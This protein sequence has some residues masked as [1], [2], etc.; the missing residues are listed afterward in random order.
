M[1]KSK[2][3]AWD[4]W[5][6]ILKKVTSLQGIS[7]VRWSWNIL[8]SSIWEEHSLGY[9]VPIWSHKRS[10]VCWEYNVSIGMP[11]LGSIPIH[12][13]L[14]SRLW[15]HDACWIQ[16]GSKCSCQICLLLNPRSI[17][18]HRLAPMKVRCFSPLLLF[19]MFSSVPLDKAVT[20]FLRFRYC[21]RQLR[22]SFSFFLFSSWSDRKVDI[23]CLCLFGIGF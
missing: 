11:L 18:K 3:Y 10:T 8:R 1:L 4:W 14:V 17:I 5:N 2:S 12:I 19:W 22:C 13:P 9:G 20:F 21:W 7:T 15:F 16:G 6:E 23:W